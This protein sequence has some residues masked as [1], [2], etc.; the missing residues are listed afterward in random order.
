MLKVS[1]N[2]GFTSFLNNFLEKPQGAKLALPSLLRVKEDGHAV[3]NC[4]DD[5]DTQSVEPALDIT[6]EKDN[7]T[8]FVEDAFFVL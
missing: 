4:E 8:T 7:I 3:I 2:Q 1:E 5:T 6:C